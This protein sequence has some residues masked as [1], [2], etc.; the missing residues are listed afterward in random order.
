VVHAYLDKRYLL[1]LAAR[2]VP[3]VP[4]TLVEHGATTELP[5]TRCVIKPAIG[6]GSLGCKVF[7]DGRHGATHLAEL[8]RA[9][10][11]LVQPYIKSGDTSGERALIWSDGAFTHAI[12]KTPRFLDD[13]ER[14]EGPVSIADDERAVATAALAPY[15]DR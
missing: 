11:A 2:G 4:T 15:R 14:V 3:V 1:E 5:S 9:G 10:A 7:A 6:A 12:R 13:R 8:T